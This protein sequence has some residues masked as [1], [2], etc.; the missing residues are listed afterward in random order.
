MKSSYNE[1]FAFADP[2]AQQSASRSTRHRMKKRR[3]AMEEESSTSQ[4]SAHDEERGPLLPDELQCSEDEQREPLPLECSEDEEREPLSPDEL[5]CSE[6]E[7]RVPL[8]PD[9]L[10]C[11]EDEEQELS[12][13]PAHLCK[14]S[15]LSVSSS[16]VLI[17]KFK[18]RHNLTQEALA[19]LLQL[20]KLHCPSPN[21]CSSSVYQFKKHF[22]DLNYPI[23]MHYFCSRCL[24]AVESV[25]ESRTCSNAHCGS[26]FS[27]A[28]S[29]SSFIEVPLDC[30]LKVLFERRR[31]KCT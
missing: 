15:S 21:Q 25:T 27:V 14:G 11:L 23:V 29:V 9:E 20:I 22:P 17:M 30:Q 6:D 18:M 24:H 7:E 19:D 12:S 16:S 3:K 28:D 13:V 31:K 2:R 1:R 10:Q 4:L 26:D 8:P 5:Q